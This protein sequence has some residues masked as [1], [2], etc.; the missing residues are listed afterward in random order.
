MVENTSRT[1]RN[2]TETDTG[3][4][5]VRGDTQLVVNPERTS[6]RMHTVSGQYIYTVYYKE[7]GYNT[8]S[9]RN[10]RNIRKTRK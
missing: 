8:I 6:V 4:L 9:T 7:T 10:T 3:H 5:E 2:T 1:R